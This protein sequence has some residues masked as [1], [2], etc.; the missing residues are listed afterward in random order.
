[1][2]AEALSGEEEAN[3]FSLK[4]S[5]SE[6]ITPDFIFDSSLQTVRDGASDRERERKRDPSPVI[7]TD[8]KKGER[9]TER[10]IRES[11]KVVRPKLQNRGSVR[12]YLYVCKNT[13]SLDT[14]DY[15]CR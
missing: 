7:E 15:V 12:L 11:I 8:Q 2:N 9:Q 6:I 14:G 5:I 3:I 13:W 10:S 1:M 4:E